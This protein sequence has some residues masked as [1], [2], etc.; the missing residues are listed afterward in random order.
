ML[1][2]VIAGG[3]MSILWISWERTLEALLCF[4]DFTHV[5]FLLADF[6]YFCYNNHSCEY[7]YIL[8]YEFCHGTMN[9]EG[10]ETSSQILSEVGFRRPTRLI[11]IWW[12][13]CFGEKR[14]KKQE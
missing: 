2:Q 4:L 13:H 1:S 6:A 5:L 14:M 10:P 3:I 9:P 11:K 12:K 8:S 7:D